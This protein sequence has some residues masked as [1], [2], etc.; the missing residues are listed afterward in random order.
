[1]SSDETLPPPP[2][3]FA[4]PPPAPRPRLPLPA[5][6]DHVVTMPRDPWS[7]LVYWGVTDDGVARARASLAGE[8]PA[9]LV[10]RLYVVE[11]A[12]AGAVQDVPVVEWNGRHLASIE[13]PGARVIAS[14]G[15]VA[16]D[17]FA[18]VARADAVRLPRTAPGDE[19]RRFEPEG[20]PRLATDPAA[21]RLEQ[22]A[23]AGADL[24]DL[25]TPAGEAR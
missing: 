5:G 11:G 3:G 2:P 17:Q 13:V 6:H 1:M 14:V 8:A 19:P 24:F 4:T 9:R 21:F 22:C 15:L 20:T 16:G 12:A 18:H 25:L 23:A 10:L 7:V